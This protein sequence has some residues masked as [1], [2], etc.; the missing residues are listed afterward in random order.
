MSNHGGTLG[1]GPILYSGS[2][3]QLNQLCREKDDEIDRLRNKII[4]IEE[5]FGLKLEKINDGEHFID[6]SIDG[7]L[8]S[9]FITYDA[10]GSF[11]TACVKTLKNIL[12]RSIKIREVL[13]D[14]FSKT[15]EVHS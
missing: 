1:L 2:R 10:V 9:V 4:Q 11:D 8:D 15:M 14:D 5:A 13:E 7:N 3:D 6:N 12:E